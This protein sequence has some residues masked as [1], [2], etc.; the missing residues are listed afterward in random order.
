[1]QEADCGRNRS[2]SGYSGLIS[3]PERESQ[4]PNLW[5]QKVEPVFLKSLFSCDFGT[6][7]S[8]AWLEDSNTATFALSVTQ[9]WRAVCTVPSS[10]L[11][12]V[13]L[14]SSSLVCKPQTVMFTQPEI[15]VFTAPRSSLPAP[16]VVLLSAQY[17]SRRMTCDSM[18]NAR[19]NAVHTD[20]SAKSYVACRP[21]A[22]WLD[23]QHWCIVPHHLF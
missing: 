16:H 14:R 21:A 3:M 17:I 20:R 1:M 10:T 13:M 4:A 23:M 19:S 15:V 7:Y 5:Q 11:A 2:A 8:D 6:F 9:H 18:F 22:T 12:S